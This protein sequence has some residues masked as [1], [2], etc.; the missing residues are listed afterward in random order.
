MP[1]SNNH[2]SSGGL[3]VVTLKKRAPGHTYRAPVKKK[4]RASSVIDN[5]EKLSNEATTEKVATVMQSLSEILARD[6]E[7]RKAETMNVKEN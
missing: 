6:I 3:S 4:T 1:L 7:G 5:I 2:C